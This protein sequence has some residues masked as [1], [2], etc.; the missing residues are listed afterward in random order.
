MAKV[1]DGKATDLSQRINAAFYT[2]QINRCL[3]NYWRGLQRT[4]E[5]S[6]PENV[7]VGQVQ[8]VGHS[9]LDPNGTSTDYRRCG[10]GLAE[11]LRPYHF[12]GVHVERSE[13]AGLTSENNKVARNGRRR[14]DTQLGFVPPTNVPVHRVDRVEEIIERAHKQRFFGKGWRAVDAV[15][16]GRLPENVAGFCIHAID[17]AV[18]T[19]YEDALSRNAGSRVDFAPQ[20]ALPLSRPVSRTHGLHVAV[21]V[22]EEDCVFR[23]DRR[24]PNL[25]AG[26]H[27]P[28]LGATARI[29]RIQRAAVTSDENLP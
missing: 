5:A 28:N 7:T 23:D 15:S 26:W 25:P 13:D 8:R 6:P 4:S 14:G 17:S 10:D 9:R 22:A 3:C 20:R 27:I 19:A 12:S 29:N 24:G 16:S 21:C 1:K 2:G 11:T 18:A